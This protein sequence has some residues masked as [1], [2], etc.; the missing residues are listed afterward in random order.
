MVR[1]DLVKWIRGLWTRK[2]PR[3]NWVSNREGMQ[4][5]AAM[6][7]HNAACV[8]LADLAGSN[9][10]ERSRDETRKNFE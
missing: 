10:E 7:K 5:L 9:A 3:S 1:S 6:E 4:R 8:H 2:V